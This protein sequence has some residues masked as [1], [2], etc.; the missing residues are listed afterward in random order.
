MARSKIFNV[1]GNAAH[2]YQST[3]LHPPIQKG[4]PPPARSEV[5]TWKKGKNHKC[6][7]VFNEAQVKLFTTELEVGTSRRRPDC[8]CTYNLPHL[9]H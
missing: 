7:V 5:V 1:D 8:K 2:H 9:L 4:G 3:Q 6:R